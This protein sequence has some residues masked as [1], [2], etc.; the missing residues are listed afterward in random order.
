MDKPFSFHGQR[1]GLHNLLPVRI[2][3]LTGQ[4]FGTGLSRRELAR[5]AD[6]WL[7]VIQQGPGLYNEDTG[8]IL[9]VNKTGRKK[10]GDNANLSAAESK[11][12]AGIEELVRYAVV[13]EGHPDL[14]H[15]NAF[16]Q[17]IYRLYAPATISG[18]LYRVKLTVKDYTGRGAKQVLHALAAIEIE[19]APPGIFPSSASEDA[20]Q[21]SQPTTG[22]TLSIARLLAGAI[23]QDHR[24]FE[25]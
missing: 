16:V 9:R 8:W 18:V 25:L 10:M 14:E 6:A 19:N 21:T 5:A 3:E 23:R 17:A 15:G 22:R 1:P 12:V 7:R 4:E 20:L 13:A 11:A 2:M 24:P